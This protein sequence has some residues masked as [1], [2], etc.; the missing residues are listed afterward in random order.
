MASFYETELERQKKGD[1]TVNT[2]L[3]ILAAL[4][5]I[6]T[7]KATRGQNVGTSTLGLIKDTY[8]RRQDALDRATKADSTKFANDLNLG[9][10][11]NAKTRLGL[12]TAQGAREASR[13]DREI[14]DQ[15]E[16]DNLRK[17]TIDRLLG[18]P[19][20]VDEATNTVTRSGMP[21]AQG[22]TMED[23]AA[24]QADPITWLKNKLTPATFTYLPTTGGYV[25]APT[26]GALGA[27]PTAGAPLSN[28]D[29]GT[30]YMPPAKPSEKTP[31][32]IEADA[33]ARAMGAAEGAATKEGKKAKLPA[34]TV[35]ELSG[36][37]E[38]IKQLNNMMTN[39]KELKKDWGPLNSLRT[40]NPF[41][42]EAQ[43]FNQLVATTKQVIGKGLEGGVLRKE[44]E[45]KYE[46]ILPGF[47]DTKETRADKAK[48]LE[49]MIINKHNTQLQ[50]LSDA[51]YDVGDIPKAVSAGT[52][53]V[54]EGTKRINQ[55]GV[56]MIMMG[57]KWQIAQ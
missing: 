37:Q 22:L 47:K 56:P 46:K 54:P 57:G 45:A 31:A 43:D 33:K 17:A 24:I 4:E 50:T 15:E 38:A 51:N 27:A 5:T 21:G 16:K 30:P 9:E 2:V 28:P 20:T 14:Q 6:A 44:D 7:A 26:K 3:P 41:D 35:L 25:P 55:Q 1:T 34:T 53:S 49:Q 11:A 23:K 52:P 18:M 19:N 39:S 42:T 36:A 29:T 32:Q 12:E 40:V 8:S 10:A 13:Y 48:Q